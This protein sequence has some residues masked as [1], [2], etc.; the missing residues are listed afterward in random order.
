M[1]SKIIRGLLSVIS[2]KVAILTISV[3]TLPILVRLLGSGNYGDYAFILSVYSILMIFV[4]AGADAGLRKYIS[5]EHKEPNWQR[6]IFGFYTRVAFISVLVAAIG[7]V[8][9]VSA[10]RHINLFEEDFNIYFLLMS[11]M[12]FASQLQSIS[13]S[14]LLGLQLEHYSEPLRVL[15]EFLFS[16]LAVGLLLIGLGVSGVLV[17]YFLSSLFIGLVSLYYVK[18]NLGKISILEPAPKSVPRRRLLSYNAYTIVLTL[19]ST[20]LYHIDILLLQPFAG[21]VETG[22]YRASLQIGEFL[23]FVPLAIQTVFLHSSSKMWS[24]EQVG[25]ITSTSSLVTRYTILFTS[26]LAIGLFVLANSFMPLYFGSEFSASV[27]PL[28]LLLPGIIGFAVARPIY[29]IG[30][31]KSGSALR[32]LIIATGSA[33]II[34]LFLNLILIPNYGMHGAAVATSVGY[35]SM[36]VFHIIAARRIGFN[37]IRNVRLLPIFLTIFFSTPIIIAIDYVILSDIMSLIVVPPLGFLVFVI[38]GFVTSAINKD[39]IVELYTEVTNN[40]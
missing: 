8:I 21:S 22:Y 20:S 32:V 24:N 4:H 6:S 16:I 15:R 1:K 35:S 30:K 19:L 13:R 12:I 27:L 28:I 34:N 3:I 25:K 31:A 29:S 17:A 5:E 33:A 23:W 18:Q 40:I 7:V 26:L 38:V 11:I 36:L 9:T 14:S 2:G 37:P 10:N 39:E